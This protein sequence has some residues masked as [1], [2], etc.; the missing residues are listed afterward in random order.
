MVGALRHAFRSTSPVLL[1]PAFQYYILPILMYCS[2][3][4]NPS[5]KKDIDIVERIQRSFTKRLRGMKDLSYEERL[6]E[7]GAPTLIYRRL[8]ADLVFIF[9]CLHGMVDINA[10]D[11]GLS[12]N[13]S[14]TRGCGSKLQQYRA[15]TRTV[16]ALFCHRVQ[17]QWNKLPSVVVN[18]TSVIQFKRLL[19]K[20]IDS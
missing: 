10:A 5:L 7:L 4:W 9:K 6:N 11:I 12:L 18:C 2:P 19:A 15:S 8:C 14:N 3:S 1:W 16:G 20:Y 17:S 13:N